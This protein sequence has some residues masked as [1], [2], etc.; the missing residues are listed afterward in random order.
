VTQRRRAR[1]E[2]DQRPRIARV[3]AI[4][5]VAF[6]AVLLLGVLFLGVFPTRTYLRQ[7]ASIQSTEHQLSVLQGETSRLRS[8]IGRLRTPAEI[9]RIAREDYNL[10]RPGE[11][12]FLIIPSE[13][14]ALRQGSRSSEAAAMIRALWGFDPSVH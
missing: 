5:R 8:D 6:A 3:G 12:V 11:D 14:E 10:A 1:P 4:A 13:E 7:R 2:G 9:E